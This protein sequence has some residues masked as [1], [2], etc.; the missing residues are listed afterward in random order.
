MSSEWLPETEGQF[1]PWWG[2][3]AKWV[4]QVG[5]FIWFLAN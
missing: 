1:V 3:F 5:K 2:S 4:L